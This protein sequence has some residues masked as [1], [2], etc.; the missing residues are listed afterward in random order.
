MK[1]KYQ[2]GLKIKLHSQIKKRDIYFLWLIQ[3]HNYL[4]SLPTKPKDKYKINLEK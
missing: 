2:A 4:I 1:N 3:V